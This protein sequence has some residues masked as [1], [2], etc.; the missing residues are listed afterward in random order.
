M[1][2]LLKNILLVFAV[3]FLFASLPVSAAE[4]NAGQ[5]NA[6][7]QPVDFSCRGVYLGDSS[8][9]LLQA[10]GT[11]LFEKDITVQGIQVHCYTFPHDFTAGVAVKRDKVVDFTIKNQQYEARDGVKYG[12]TAYKIKQ[13]YGKQQ[14]TFFEGATYYIYENPEHKYQR[15]L[16]EA[17]P[18]DGWLLSMRIT[19]LPLTDEEAETM[20]EDGDWENN[21]LQA[22]TMADKNVDTTALDK[23]EDKGE[24][25]LKIKG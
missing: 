4:R 24:V 6:G 11:P 7:L 10:F 2:S 16:I 1:K 9:K 21:D 14:R 3:L 17:E 20:T 18:T 8:A 13:T 15:L 5:R 23:Q 12:A 19:S 25:K 22:I